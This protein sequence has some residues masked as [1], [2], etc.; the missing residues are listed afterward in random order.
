MHHKDGVDRVG[1]LAGSIHYASTL[2]E[3]DMQEVVSK[4][5]SGEGCGGGWRTRG[6]WVGTLELFQTHRQENVAGGCINNDHHAVLSMLSF[7]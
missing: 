2:I 5:T 3:K 4:N 6:G 1:R 7:P